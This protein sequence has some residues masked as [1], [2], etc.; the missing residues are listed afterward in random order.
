[1]GGSVSGVAEGLGRVVGGALQ[2]IGDSEFHA[3]LVN[4]VVTD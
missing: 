4:V 2:A 3:R 1:M